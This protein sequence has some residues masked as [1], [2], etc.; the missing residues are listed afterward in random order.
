M[1]L[2]IFCLLRCVRGKTGLGELVPS[3][4]FVCRVPQ[5]LDYLLLSTDRLTYLV[6]SRRDFASRFVTV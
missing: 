1:S 5:I 4:S 3:H 2:M 6:R